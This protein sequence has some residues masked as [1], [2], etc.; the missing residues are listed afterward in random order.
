MFETLFSSI[1]EL[2]LQNSFSFL[3]GGNAITHFPEVVW[4]VMRI[5]LLV[6]GMEEGSGLLGIR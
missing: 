2:G 3:Q 5:R 6:L 1:P 4:S